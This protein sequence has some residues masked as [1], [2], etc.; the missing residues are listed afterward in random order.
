MMI[1]MVT[2]MLLTL[3]A[4]AG[5]GEDSVTDA[6]GPGPD[7]TRADVVPVEAVST[8][9][10]VSDAGG[11][12]ETA[13]PPD[14]TSGCDGAALRI[15]RFGAAGDLEV[16]FVSAGR[17]V[18][19]LL[20]WTLA[21]DGAC[22]GCERFVV[23]GLGDT[24]AACWQAG[25]PPDGPDSE[26]GIGAALLVAPGS[27][28][29]QPVEV[30]AI[31]AEHCDA[32][33][34]L[35]PA[36]TR[37]TIGSLIVSGT[38]ADHS[39]AAWGPECGV[40]ANDCGGTC[41]TDACADDQVCSGDGACLPAADCGPG[42]F[43]VGEVFLDGLGGAAEVD[44]GEQVTVFLTWAVGNDDACV[45]CQRQLVFGLDSSPLGCTDLGVTSTCPAF[46]AGNFAALFDAP[47]DPG[48][49]TLLA[50]ALTTNNCADAE[51]LYTSGGP[52]SAIGV[53]HVGPACAPAGCA[54]MGRACG[55][56]E[57]WCGELL[58]C[59]ACPTS[60]HCTPDGE[61]LPLSTCAEDLFEV[62]DLSLNGA[63]PVL[64]TEGGPVV[65]LLRW[66]AGLSGG[67]EDAAAQVVVGLGDQ[68]AFCREVE[69]PPPCEAPLEGVSGG[70]LT[71]T[72]IPGTYPVRTALLQEADCAAAL[73]AFPD[74]TSVTAGLVRVGWDC[75]PRSCGDLGLECGDWGDG[76]GH[77]LAC[78]KC[79]DGESCTADGRCETACAAGIFE[80]DG[81]E[82]NMSGTA[83][84]A[85]PG[86]Q[87]PLALHWTL[88][89]PD[90]CDGCARQLVLGIGDAAGPC[91]ELGA[92]ATCPE[93][94]DGFL[95]V[96]VTAPSEPGDH[97]VYAYAPGSDVGCAQ[98][99]A[100]FPANP[101]RLPIGEL[102]VTDGCLPENC[103]SLD[104]VCGL[105]DDGCGFELNCGECQ[106][107]QLCVGGLCT[108]SALDDYE[109][110]DLPAQAWNLGTFPDSDAE[111]SVE[112]V[113]MVEDEVDWFLMGATDEMWAYV[114]PSAHVEMGTGQPYEVQAVYI[115][116]NGTTS[117]TA[118]TASGTC[119]WTP[120]DFAGV[121]DLDG[122][123]AGW[124]C[125]SGA[126]DLDLQ[127]TPECPTIDDSGR[128][129]I[130]VGTS[131]G[132]SSYE[133]SLHL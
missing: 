79:P 111:S 97:V 93:T 67:P 130:S 55:L 64:G 117:E 86:Q 119:T 24:P 27:P 65:A 90:N 125:E 13:T 123:V 118:I 20:E 63:G 83:G 29:E 54:D 85:A 108:C 131:V 21:E 28:G 128:F 52:K 107:G 62:Q 1:R 73:D 94:A 61:C 37:L 68:P 22:P 5:A 49:Y 113:A 75:T 87:V 127:L 66:R 31:A 38:C 112:V 6:A 16:G 70:F 43:D 44:P 88:G 12:E 33:R 53:L 84:S 77:P 121:P 80:V 99:E 122:P 45:D 30:A 42:I 133:L 103:F 18:P 129:F 17:D 92:P 69:A 50:Q 11:P 109:D 39:C 115:C 116:S 34:E 104:A 3:S 124:R 40:W 26:P 110:N 51:T 46:D 9:A 47:V 120:M 23:L 2:V 95:S 41:P 74:A 126:G 78:G 100:T 101:E 25:A 76:C 57:D 59:G 72:G 48:T 32:A 81:V 132:C 36:E 102:H 56:W 105:Q 106:A 98:A 114:N 4:C 89:N 10:E 8:D 19:V 82:V 7:L 35:Y 60:K 91:S 15:T 96:F 71:I 58:D 14:D